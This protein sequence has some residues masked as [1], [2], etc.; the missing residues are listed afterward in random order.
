MRFVLFTLYAP[1][2]SFGEIAVGEHRMG[3]ARPGRSAILGL[4]AAAKGIERD[5]EEGH[6]RLD[7]DLHYAVRT[8]AVGR[9]FVDYHTT[10]TP[11]ARKGRRFSTRRDELRSA[12]LHT[13]QSRR[14]WR[15]DACFTVAL[16]ARPE[17]AVDLDALVTALR[18][19]HFTLYA[20]RKSAPPGLP[21]HPT[22]VEADDVLTAFESRERNELEQEI[23]ECVEVPGVS[24]REIAFDHGAVGAPSGTRV[25][26]RRDAVASRARWQFAERLEGVL[27]PEEREG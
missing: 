21:L 25:E 27:M 10:Q 20:G 24:A 19:P 26:R 3:W 2:A 11:K 9:P 1:M 4:V 5:D 17:S 8:D 6:L 15:T 23:L 7:A 18:H 16:W 13:V 22:V 12:D 14:E